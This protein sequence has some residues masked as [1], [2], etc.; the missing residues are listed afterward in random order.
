MKEVRRTVVGAVV[1]C[2]AL[3]LSLGGCGSDDSKPRTAADGTG[4]EPGEGGSGGGEPGGPAAEE[5]P[6]LLAPVICQVATD[7]LGRL[8]PL[9]LGP[10]DCEQHWTRGLQD[11]EFGLL[12]AAIE[13]GLVE[14]HPE[15]VED[16]INEL[17]TLGCD[18]FLGWHSEPCEAAITGT[19]AEGRECNLDF[20]CQD[21]LFC[22]V[23]GSC[24]GSCA[25]PGSAGEACT[26]NEH[27][28]QDLV[29][30]EGVGQCVEAGQEGDACREADAPCAM[31]LLCMD[32]DTEAGTPGTCTDLLAAF[33]AGEADACSI[34]ESWQLCQEGL[35]C[36]LTGAAAGTCS[37]ERAL[38]GG[39][40]V[41][42]IPDQCPGDEYCDTEGAPPFCR[43]LPA[44]GDACT[45]ERFGP[46]CAA[47]HVCV[48]GICRELRR[49]GESCEAD[50][51]CYSESCDRN[52]CVRGVPCEPG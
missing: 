16:C 50:A 32:E 39:D 26:A 52:S 14:Y 27:C 10:G 29:C 51:Q 38:S 44:A 1:G 8:A 48:D 47:E 40:C 49:L 41:A 4:G 22:R 6:A 25:A 21:D 35:Y 7:C 31:P 43:P 42:T 2:G 24:P 37:S 11:G 20:E 19:V 33:S 28:A 17:R 12:P 13:D 15:N 3:G 9:M 36:V 5:L 46:T 18:F 45:Y 23:E 30:A 34:G